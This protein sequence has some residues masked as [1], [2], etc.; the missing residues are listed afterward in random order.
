MATTKPLPQ[1]PS[2]AVIPRLTIEASGHLNSLVA[3]AIQQRGLHASWVLPVQGA[4]ESLATWMSRGEWLKGIYAERCRNNVEGKEVVAKEPNSR[5][6]RTESAQ[7][8][9]SESTVMVELPGTDD[10]EVQNRKLFE[11]ISKTE[12]EVTSK[13]LLLAVAEPVYPQDI[14]NPTSTVSAHPTC[15]FHEGAFHLPYF[16]DTE[17]AEHGWGGTILCGLDSMFNIFSSLL[18]LLTSAIQMYPITPM[19]L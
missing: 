10:S 9:I 7:S 2:S 8:V 6:K 14:D 4:L 18:R 17:G 16:K 13:H 3:H 19:S 12:T 15:I 5:P 1:L 11:L